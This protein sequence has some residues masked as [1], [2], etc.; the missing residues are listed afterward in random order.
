MSDDKYQQFFKSFKVA[1]T[2]GSFYQAGHPKFLSAVKDLKEKLGVL[3]NKDEALSIRIRQ[4]AL[5]IDE[6]EFNDDAFCQD[7]AGSLHLKK[8]KTISLAKD[9]PVN[10]LAVFLLK[11]A[12]NREEVMAAGGMRKILEEAGVRK[13]SI[14]LLD[15]SQ[16]MKGA[17][18]EVKNAW[19]YLWELD[20]AEAEP[21]GDALKRFSVKFK[22]AVDQFGVKEL[23][24]DPAS[25]RQLLATLSLLK[26]K[27]Q[28]LLVKALGDLGRGILQGTQLTFSGDREKIAELF[29]ALPPED[30]RDL[31]LEVFVSEQNAEPASFQ[32]FS[33]LISSQARKESAALVGASGQ[34][35]K[36]SLNAGKVKDLL[37]SLKSDTVTADYLK[38]LMRHMPASRPTPEVFF[39]YDHLYDNY[40]LILLDLLARETKPQKLELIL[41]RIAAQLKEPSLKNLEYFLQFKTIYDERIQ[42]NTLADVLTVKS[43]EIWAF[44]EK[45]HFHYK[46]ASRFCFLTEVLNT[47]CLDEVY[48]LDKIFDEKQYNELSLRL[49]FQFFPN[50]ILEF[51][52]RL[53]LKQNEEGFV[54]SLVDMLAGIND[55]LSLEVLTH[56]F[57]KASLVRKM[58]LLDKLKSFSTFDREFLLRVIRT[59]NF[60]LRRKAVAVAAE[61]PEL[62]AEIARTLFSAHYYFSFS[63]RTL[64]DD[65]EILSE[66]YI[67]EVRPYLIKLSKDILFWNRKLK[68]KA[69]QILESYHDRTN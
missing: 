19:D 5:I 9:V 60:A 59:D 47:S 65:L 37:D 46:D 14:E 10:E 41:A 27:D 40:R 15:Y 29:R 12:A 24:G 64:L 30:I 69:K 11:V 43:H 52:A 28:D 6:K 55:S 22:Q 58:A 51:C 8:I 34:D 68:A 61:F 63:N 16:L 33:S 31:L 62:R 18:E 1:L 67:P 25:S 57:Q 17:G 56:I 3:V 38:D 26:E 39:D 53:D 42:D 45:E 48:Y 35:S 7:L 4:D 20:R 44:A 2:N 21:D 66:V 13:V 49:F 23:L 50:E 54:D 32:L 36:V